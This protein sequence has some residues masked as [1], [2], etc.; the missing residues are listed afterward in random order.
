MNRFS[1]AAL[2]AMLVLA[3]G[4][5]YADDIYKWVD[6][7][8]RTHFGSSP[9][10]GRKAERLKTPSTASEP[11]SETSPGHTW[12]QQLQAANE[13]REQ[14]RKQQRETVKRDRENDRRC[15]EARRT[16][17]MLDRD[18]PVFRVDA[19]GEREYMEDSQRQASRDAAN[20]NV[21]EYC[22]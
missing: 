16:L 11:P 2:V 18:R 21:A 14:A 20:Q 17:R 22:R 7:Q 8:G 15:A 6:E 9:P 4:A 10:P 5:V 1:G 3:T 12:Q 13:R 19:K